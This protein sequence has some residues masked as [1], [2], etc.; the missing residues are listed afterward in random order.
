MKEKK[1]EIAYAKDTQTYTLQ[2]T[3][4]IHVVLCKNGNGK[5]KFMEVERKKSL[6]K[7]NF[8]LW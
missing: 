4:F 8:H 6:L 1:S 3:R 2:L 7:K 5:A